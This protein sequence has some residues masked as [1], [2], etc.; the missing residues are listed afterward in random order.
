MD[1]FIARQPIFDRDQ[2]V[3]AYELLYRTGEMNFFDGSVSSNVATS[4]LLMNSYFSFGMENLL[5]EEKAFINFDKHLIE[6]DIPRLLNKELVVIELLE[7]IVPDPP[8]IEK[9]LSL[10]KEGYTIALDD[11]VEGYEYDQLTEIVDIIK[12][13]FFENTQDQIAKLVKK[14][15]RKGKILLAEK[16]ETREVYD[17]AK[18]IGFDYFQG[19][20]FSKPSMMKSK[21]L[22]DN[23]FQYIQLMEELNK[24]EPNN[25]SI[26]KIIETDVILTYKL[27]KLVNS[28]FSLSS[29]VNSINHAL[30]I[31]GSTAFEKWL[32]LAMVQ[33]LSANK[34]SELT[35]SSMIRSAFMGNIAKETSM[36]NKLDEINLT[37]ILSVLDALLDKS[38]EEI[39][40]TLPLSKDIKSALLFEASPYLPFCQLAFSYEKG[41]F[42]GLTSICE[43]INYDYEKLPQAYFA[44]VKWAE[45]LFAI[46]QE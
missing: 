24:K 3:I 25:G 22:D 46:M 42:E 31:L 6:A 2:N 15:K 21:K 34:P 28:S 36:K 13:D 17:W 23:A 35:K 10:K 4:I 11:Y 19:Y 41:D 38:M 12:F 45:E 1:V 33:N 26:S 8:F 43:S 39:V 7:D 44:A 16:V 29:Q 27:L 30:A 5:G 40:E 37:G 14:W 32:S 9:V 18:D 20:F